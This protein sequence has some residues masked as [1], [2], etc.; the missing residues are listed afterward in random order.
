[1]GD[2][3]PQRRRAL[4]PPPCTL[5][6]R[7]P[8]A[9][10]QRLDLDAFILLHPASTIHRK[11]WRKRRSADPKATGPVHSARDVADVV[12]HVDETG[13]QRH[14]CDSQSNNYSDC[15]KRKLSFHGM[16]IPVVSRL[17]LQFR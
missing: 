7:C 9:F 12:C 11:T 8:L 15:E 2:L 10:S 6:Q 3:L 1:M 13:P 16:R 14:R 17:K 4:K 5:A